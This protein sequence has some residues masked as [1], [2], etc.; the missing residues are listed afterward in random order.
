MN[1]FDFQKSFE[2]GDLDTEYMDFLMEYGSEYGLRVSN[3]DSLLNL[4][5]SMTLFDE[6][7]KYMLNKK[8]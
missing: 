6:F 1:I 2:S 8:S 7:R 5:E 3:G 4:F